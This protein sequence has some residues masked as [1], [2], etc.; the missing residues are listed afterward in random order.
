MKSIYYARLDS[1]GLLTT[2]LQLYT[3]RQAIKYW[4][5]LEKDYK[6][7]TFDE[8]ILKERY[9]FIVILCGTSVTQLLGQNC[10]KVKDNKVD[11][12]KTL[13]REAIFDKER[14]TKTVF[15]KFENFID[16]YE[17]KDER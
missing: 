2:N 16:D 12:P 1:G 6:S 11:N 17:Y 5:Q 14:C 9:V 13:F 10:L 3:V 8:N 7:K 4:L 15:K